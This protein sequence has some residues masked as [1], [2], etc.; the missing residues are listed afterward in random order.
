MLRDK[1][2]R[3]TLKLLETAANGGIVTQFPTSLTTRDKTGIEIWRWMVE[4]NSKDNYLAAD[5]DSLKVGITQLYGGGVTPGG[6]SQ[7]VGSSVAGVVDWR[8]FSV[9]DHGTPATTIMAQNN[10]V[11]DLPHHPIVHP[12]SVYGFV[13]GESQSNPIEC[14][15]S[16]EFTYVDLTEQDYLDILQTI[17]VQNSL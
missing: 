10:L 17:I 11:F 12:A 7:I 14:Y 15:I 8:V 13:K 9:D 3:I 6:T 1:P 2:Q 5:L 4:F 16:L